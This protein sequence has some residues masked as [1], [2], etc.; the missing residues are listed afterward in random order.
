MRKAR[1]G[2]F[3]F[4][5]CSVFTVTGVSAHHHEYDNIDR[6]AAS[7]QLYSSAVN[8]AQMPGRILLMRHAEKP[9]D[10]RNPNLT[11]AGFMRANDLVQFVQS[12][13][14]RPDYIF[15]A[16]NSKHSCRPLETALPLSKATGVPICLNFKDDDFAELAST[17]RSDSRFAGK[18]VVIV[19]HHGN[20]PEF[21]QALQARAG[22]YPVKWPGSCY[23]EILQF[24]YIGGEHPVVSEV[25]EP[26]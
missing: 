6:S 25:R 12:R 16:D 26:Y 19:W 2:I 9:D 7:T 22:T 17:L 18:L 21:A 3:S 13:Y 14:G 8:S 10:D 5:L 1:A 4:L 24:D 20:I 11:P 15:A 23:N